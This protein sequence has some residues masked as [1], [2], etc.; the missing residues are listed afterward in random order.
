[1]NF[2]QV[3]MNELFT[4]IIK[5]ETSF[6]FPCLVVLILIGI[7]NEVMIVKR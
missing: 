3:I 6:P 4:T 1:M 2:V 5:I 7:D